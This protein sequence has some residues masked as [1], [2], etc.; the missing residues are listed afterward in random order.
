MLKIEAHCSAKG[1]FYAVSFKLS[2]QGN[3][4]K[5]QQTKE[6]WSSNRTI[7]KKLGS[8]YLWEDLQQH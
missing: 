6:L 8:Y 7:S 2:S 1:G 5:N 3:A 4:S